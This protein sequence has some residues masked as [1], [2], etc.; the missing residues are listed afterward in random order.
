VQEQASLPAQEDLLDHRLGPACTK[1]KIAPATRSSGT[2][3]GFSDPVAW[4]ESL[5][6]EEVLALLTLYEAELV[7]RLALYS[8][9]AA[10]AERDPH[11]SQRETYLWRRIHENFIPDLPI[12]A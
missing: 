8:G 1:T 10:R 11:R 5:S 6:D 2:P 7:D 4:A 3:Q 9:Q 12:R